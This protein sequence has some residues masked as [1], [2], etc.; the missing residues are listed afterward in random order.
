MSLRGTKQSSQSNFSFVILNEVKRSWKIFYHLYFIQSMKNYIV[1]LSLSTLFLAGCGQV[2]E[3]N[4]V[5]TS[6]ETW[7]IVSDTVITNIYSSPFWFT[8]EYN[9]WRVL[10]SNTWTDNSSITT[11]SNSWYQISIETERTAKKTCGHIIM[12]WLELNKFTPITINWNKMMRNNKLQQAYEI[13]GWYLD[14]YN[15]D[16]WESCIVWKN[17]WPLYNKFKIKYI[18]PISETDFNIWN[19]NTEYLNEMD[20]IVSSITLS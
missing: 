12:S 20:K 15:S 3:N 17:N 7:N 18:L 8:F 9:S 10:D 16:N 11:I 14:V 5:Q 19:F 6:L 1:L 13:D 2:T 4:T